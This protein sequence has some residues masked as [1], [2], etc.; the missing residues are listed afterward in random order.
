[1]AQQITNWHILCSDNRYLAPE[2]RAA[3]VIGE[4]M[5]PRGEPY[6]RTSQIHTFD[7][8]VCTTRSGSRYELVGDP[9][10]NFSEDYE[11]IDLENPFAAFHADLRFACAKR[12][13]KGIGPNAYCTVG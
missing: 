2:M 7:G 1:M 5:G 12:L 6:I 9:N 4:C 13:R 11:D 8:R 3:V 10:P